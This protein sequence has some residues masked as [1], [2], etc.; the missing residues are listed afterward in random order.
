MI[1]LMT[2]RNYSLA[3][4]DLQEQ[5]ITQAYSVN[6]TILK[7]IVGYCY[8]LLGNSSMDEILYS[9]HYDANIALEALQQNDNLRKVSSLITSSYFINFKTH[10]II[11][12]NG[13]RN[14]SNHPDQEIFEML[15][16][17]TPSATPLFCYPRKIS[18][19]TNQRLRED[20]PVLTM[21]FY[22]NK[23]GALVVNLN[24]ETYREMLSL[25]D[26][27]YLDIILVGSS[28]KVICASDS[29][30][31][32]Q[33]Y[34]ENKLYQKIQSLTP[35]RGSFMYIANGNRYGIKY[36]KNVGLGITYICSLN[37][38]YVYTENSMLSS[39]WG[40]T[41]VYLFIGIVLSF[42]LSWLI[43]QPLNRLK[44]FIASK[45][46]PS[47]VDAR[48]AKPLN[49]FQFLSNAY[50]EI[51]DINF[52]LQDTN[53]VFQKEHRNKI[54]QYLLIDPHSAYN[55]YET[56]LEAIT[57]GFPN[58]YY[59]I[60]LFGI[61]Q[62]SL[63]TEMETEVNLLKY[64]ILNVTNELLAT[65]FFM[66][67]IDIVSPYVILLANFDTWE[68]QKILELIA[69]VQDS[70]NKQYEITFSVGIGDSVQD[71]TELSVSYES[72]VEAFSR[73]FLTGTSS[74]HTASE[75]AL[76]P[77]RNQ[78]YPFAASDTLIS[79]IRSMSISDIPVQVHSFISA[80]ESYNV[81]L[82][83]CF[84]LQLSSSLQKL[85]AA[86]YIE[87]NDGWDYKSLEQSTLSN[88]E[89]KLTSRCLYDIEQLKN[90][91]N[92]SAKNKKLTD[93]ILLLV[94][95]NIYNPA[96]SVV[97]IADQVHLS[98]NYLR[99]IFQKNTGESLSGYINRKKLELICDL[100]QNTDESLADISDKLGF[101]TK[102]YFFTF[103]KKQTGVTPSD[104]R[105]QRKLDLP[106]L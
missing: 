61:D 38:L 24:Y 6:Q 55:A 30:L 73:R 95:E 96:L 86:N 20:L 82:I 14:I 3:L 71:L 69:R 9:D 39:L 98:V 44:H 99:N 92:A 27:N 23:L 28:G 54:L 31:F 34:S 91:R 2:N 42:L 50:Q 22:Q 70:I 56:E 47:S 62:T 90:I 65:A 46:V 43:Y 48:V 45:A 102:N 100:L 58:K 67:H 32:E 72:A 76:T 29:A 93:Q 97:F 33:D 25:D 59:R 18:N 104:Y 16:Q 49:D 84:I 8:T 106:D 63:K 53:S 105:K 66:Q 77:V 75:L 68:T 7:D 88:I 101:T 85:E 78:Q 13:R 60:I 94:E 37:K 51:L 19:I 36:I 4:E 11:D 41:F 74:V 57:A 40:Y 10:T 17:M 35:K 89:Q 21:V 15:E 26:S 52:R 103:F 1:F 80:L 83:L 64:A 12:Q 79:S 87:T 81:E 5:T